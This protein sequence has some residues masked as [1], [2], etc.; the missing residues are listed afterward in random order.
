M[1][2]NNPY[3]NNFNTQ[4]S[5]PLGQVPPTASM[6]SPA[7]PQA[8]Q[9]SQNTINKKPLIFVAILLVI[10]IAAIIFVAVFSSNR[11]EMPADYD[12]LDTGGTE[13]DLP[14]N[15]SLDFLAKFN[16]SEDNINTITMKILDYLSSY[17][18]NGFNTV[19]YNI[20]SVHK[21]SDGN[22]LIF[23]FNTDNKDVTFTAT[24]ISNSSDSDLSIS[25]SP[26]TIISE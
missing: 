26:S 6:I 3:Q 16:V 19:Y 12:P 1:Y 10:A 2:N 9:A 17:Y 5:G 4:T 11:D 24:I 14:E 13:I 8:P 21:S 15:E 20:S 7:Q 25:I 23:N 22:R 18:P